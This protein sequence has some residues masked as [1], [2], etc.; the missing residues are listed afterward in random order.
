MKYTMKG[1]FDKFHRRVQ[2]EKKTRRSKSKKPPPDYS[3]ILQDDFDQWDYINVYG[4][5]DPTWSDGANMNLKRN[6][7]LHGK[8]RIEENLPEEEYPPIYYR[9]TPP[10]MDMDYMARVD[11][12]RMNAKKS[13]EIYK[14]DPNYLW[15]C[16]VVEDLTPKQVKST[17]IDSVINYVTNLERY[18]EMDSLVDMRRHERTYTYLESFESCVERVRS[19]MNKEV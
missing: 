3:K 17:H 16:G 18:I 12:I 1:L 9:T 14:A 8:R 7:I 4:C 11:E 13:L 6:H 2:P 10:K 15:L 5:S 19:A